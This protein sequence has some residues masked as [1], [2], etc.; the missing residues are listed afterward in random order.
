MTHGWRLH[1]R[2]L[3]IPKMGNAPDENEDAAYP[4]T[5]N[6]PIELAK[7]ES[8]SCALSDGATQSSFSRLWANLL[9]DEASRASIFDV[10]PVGILEHAIPRWKNQVSQYDLPWHAEEKVR[11]GAFA[12]L[13]WLGIKIMGGRQ[14][15]MQG[16]WKALVLGDSC[17]FHLRDGVPISSVPQLPGPDFSQNPVL[18]S[19]I[20]ERNR[21]ILNRISSQITSGD[22]RAGDQFILV[23]DALAEW[24][25]KG[26]G[27]GREPFKMIQT[28]VFDAPSNSS[29]FAAWVNSLREEKLI[30]NDDTT[31]ASVALE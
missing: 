2:V 21:L 23:T 4:L 7:G 16:S 6:C 5:S 24:I 15:S 8:F 12:T 11:R 14:K 19:S 13:V 10:D 18:F 27:S 26:Y 17:L 25:F 29:S 3:T 20:G 22:C 28:R 9:A 1:W 30:K 31:L